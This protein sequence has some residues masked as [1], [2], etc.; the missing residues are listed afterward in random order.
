MSGHIESVHDYAIVGLL[1]TL[2]LPWLLIACV[3]V[4]PLAVIGWC[5]CAVFDWFSPEPQPERE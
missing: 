5:A 1:V 3:F 4:V 2:G